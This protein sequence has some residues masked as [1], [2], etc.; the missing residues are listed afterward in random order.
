MKFKNPIREQREKKEAERRRK[1]AEAKK[2]KKR[3][4]TLG[5]VAFVALFIIIGIGSLTEDNTTDPVKPTPPISTV[6]DSSQPEETK[7]IVS[8][9]EP[10]K[11]DT[12]S[13]TSEPET[14]VAPIIDLSS[15]PAYSGSPYV[16]INGNVPSFADDELTT[17]SFERYSP[18]D[19]LGRCGVAYASIGIDLMPTADRGSIGQ[20]K[21][22]GWHTVKYNGVV[23]GNYLYNRCHLIGYQLTAENANT[24]NLI[25]GT[26]YL[27]VEGMLPFENMVADYIHETEN[28][29]LYRVTPIFERNNLIASGVLMEAKSVEDNGDGILFS[30]YCYN[31][32][33][34][35]TIDYATGDSS[36]NSGVSTETPAQETQ[37]P[38]QPGN[39]AGSAEATYILNTNTM[40]FHNPSCSSINQM[41][42][43]NKQ[44][45]TGSRDN[46]ISQ[47][48]DPCQRC[49]P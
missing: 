15:I 47:G 30:V 12:P 23:D 4:I 9:T 18:L 2:K 6:E 29:V 43:A 19:S 46:L 24:Q 36:L 49:N 26:R 7:P 37:A 14:T 32:Q 48:Y 41:S 13:E 10:P 21:P 11:E 33:P 20:V 35:I 40:K 16:E 44:E 45:Y 27:N 39:S 34:N 25:T 31:V 3:A 42:D 17:T 8:E 22:S 38:V 1:E 28:H 5:A